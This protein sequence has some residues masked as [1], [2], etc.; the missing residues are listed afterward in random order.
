MSTRQQ[1][2]AE[3]ILDAGENDVQW[4]SYQFDPD[5]LG[6][7]GTGSYRVLAIPLDV[8]GNQGQEVA[9]DFEITHPS[10]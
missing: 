10:V 2:P 7:P 6:V 3:I 9:N 4:Q 8:S 1:W 5:V